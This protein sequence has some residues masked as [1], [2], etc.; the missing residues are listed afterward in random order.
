MLSIFFG[1]FIGIIGKTPDN[2]IPEGLFLTF[3]D[4]V[5]VLIFAHP[6]RVRSIFLEFLEIVEGGNRA[7]YLCNWSFY[8]HIYVLGVFIGIIGGTPLYYVQKLQKRTTNS[9]LMGKI[10]TRTFSKKVK[11]EAQEY[12]YQGSPLPLLSTKTQKT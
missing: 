3:F 8:R 5:S 7:R 11:K 9:V 2:R 6:N 10:K 12:L 4:K 1:V